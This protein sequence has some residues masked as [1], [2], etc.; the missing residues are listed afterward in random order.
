MRQED[1]ARTCISEVLHRVLYPN[2]HKNGIKKERK[3]TYGWI[4]I[5][6]QGSLNDSLQCKA[7]SPKHN[8]YMLY[9]ILCTLQNRI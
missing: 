3:N 8:T 7:S 2:V 4:E 9:L 1:N 6:E 5:K